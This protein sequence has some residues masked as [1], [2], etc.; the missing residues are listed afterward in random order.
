ME[1]N[2]HQQCR[3][4]NPMYM[5]S[6]AI[7]LLISFLSAESSARIGFTREQCDA[8]YGQAV[9]ETKMYSVTMVTYRKNSVEIQVNFHEGRSVVDHIAYTMDGERL[10]E[11]EVMR[12]LMLNCEGCTWSKVV[13]HFANAMGVPSN[14][15]ISCWESSSSGTAAYSWT[16]DLWNRSTLAISSPY[17]WKRLV[18]DDARKDADKRKKELEKINTLHDL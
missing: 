16:D 8:L 17:V 18:E 14:R 1:N 4:E 10:P 6:V 5:I 7:L 12:L 9:D 2:A 11:D 15:I 13:G 3:H